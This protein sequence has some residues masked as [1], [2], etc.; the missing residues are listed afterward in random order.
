MERKKSPLLEFFF[1]IIF[2]T[3]IYATQFYS[4][5]L[6]HVFAEL[7]SI[8]IGI[9]VF[10]IAWNARKNI[11][12]FFYIGLGISALFVS[13][14]DL[15]HTLAYKGMNIFLGYDAN[16]PTQLWIGA[17]YLQA[18]SL[19]ISLILMIKPININIL[20]TGYLIFASIL[21]F[22]I[23]LGFFPNCYIEG[24]GLTQ[25][26]IISEYIIILLFIISLLMLYHN[27]NEF[28]TKVYKYLTAAFIITIFSEL[29]FTNYVSVYGIFNLI[30][31]LMKIIAFYLIYKA[32]IQIGFGEPIEILYRKLKKSEELYRKAYNRADLY[33]DI[34]THDMNNILQVISS[35]IELTQKYIKKDQNSEKIQKFSNL[36]EDQILRGARLINNIRKLSKIEEE[37]VILRKVNLNEQMNHAI[38]NFKMVKYKKKVKINIIHTDERIHVFADDLLIDVFDNLLLNAL[39]YNNNDTVEIEIIISKI[40]ENYT[41]FIKLK[42]KDNGIGIMDELKEIIFQNGYDMKKGGKGM[43]IGLSL[44]S[45]LLANYGGKIRVEDRIQGDYQKGSNFIVL[46]REY[47]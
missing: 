7:L 2:L 17:R 44:V 41:P 12:N 8:I 37:G 21:V 19:F 24:Q 31:H 5:L 14:I 27:K 13:L 34:F 42:F 4:Y 33:K 25:F 39:K 43:G 22:L 40:L 28:N 20:F 26:K 35:S 10:V 36:I 29:S 38:Q 15:I 9:N 32:I 30:G 18:V 6:F 23:F 47:I 16:L 11:D 45:K 46:L 1:L 3:G